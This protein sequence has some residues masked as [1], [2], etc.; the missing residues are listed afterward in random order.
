MHNE[1]VSHETGVKCLDAARGQQAPSASVAQ[2]PPKA[3]TEQ[4]L[5]T[6]S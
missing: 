3:T 6:I 4:F 1:D 5:T 2:I